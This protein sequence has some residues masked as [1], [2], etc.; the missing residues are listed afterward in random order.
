MLLKTWMRRLLRGDERWAQN[1]RLVKH[2]PLIA[3]T[4]ESGR[5]GS[6]ERFILTLAAI[7]PTTIQIQPTT[8]VPVD[9]LHIEQSEI[10]S[11]TGP[12]ICP[13][14][15]QAGPKPRHVPIL[16]A[17]QTGRFCVVSQPC[18]DEPNKPGSRTPL[19]PK[20]W[21]NLMVLSVVLHFWPGNINMMLSLVLPPWPRDISLQRAHVQ[22]HLAPPQT[23]LDDPINV[24]QPRFH[25]AANNATQG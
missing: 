7:Q 17:R 13:V 18:A 23:C 25:A 21:H 3:T 9:P 24:V 22:H 4:R 14:T 5:S 8:R 1:Q 20:I 15:V 19:L 10:N 12:C 6:G 16:K 2:H 11:P